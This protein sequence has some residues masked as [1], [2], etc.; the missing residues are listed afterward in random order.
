M[1][2]TLHHL[3]LGNSQKNVLK[4]KQDLEEQSHLH[5][6]GWDKTVC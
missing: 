6:E 1:V 2:V 5:K 3:Y 4:T